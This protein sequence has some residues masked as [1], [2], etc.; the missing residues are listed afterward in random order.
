MGQSGEKS[1]KAWT[2]AMAENLKRIA[3][4]AGYLPRGIG[5]LALD[6]G[7][8]EKT[9]RKALDGGSQS[10]NPRT[11]S[12]LAKALKVREEELVLDEEPCLA[13]GV[14]ELERLRGTLKCFV[15]CPGFEA[16]KAAL[17][18]GKSVVIV[19]PP[20]SGKTF[21]AVALAAEMDLR[22]VLL[23]EAVLAERFEEVRRLLARA[24]PSVV[25]LD[26]AF[27]VF[28]AIPLAPEVTRL[29][30][31]R[32]HL[33][34]VTSRPVPYSQVAVRATFDAA[35][36]HTLTLGPCADPEELISLAIDSC[37]DADKPRL[38]SRVQEALRERLARGEGGLAGEI[39]FTVQL[40]R[41]TSASAERVPPMSEHPLADFARALLA[42]V[43][44]TR[45]L[46]LIAVA[47]GDGLARARFI[48]YFKSLLHAWQGT[49]HPF[50]MM[51]PEDRFGDFHSVVISGTSIGFEHP[52]VAEAFR[53]AIDQDF[54]SELFAAQAVLAEIIGAD[55]EYYTN[56]RYFH[57]SVWGLSA[58]LALGNSGQTKEILRL[59][60][61]P[62]ESIVVPHSRRTG[63]IRPMENFF[64]GT[65]V[66]TGD[67]VIVAAALLSRAAVSREI[68]SQIL[69]GIAE[70]WESGVLELG[71][72][73]AVWDGIGWDQC[74]Q[75]VPHSLRALHLVGAYDRLVAS[76]HLSHLR[77]GEGEMFVPRLVHGEGEG[78]RL[79]VGQDDF[80]P[81]AATISHRAR[82]GER[83][84]VVEVGEHEE[85]RFPFWPVLTDSGI[86]SLAFWID[87]VMRLGFDE[88]F[89]AS[90]ESSIAITGRWAVENGAAPAFIRHLL[91]GPR[92]AEQRRRIFPQEARW[93]HKGAT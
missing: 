36:T 32:R 70:L 10:F 44:L 27:G 9:L 16:A 88:G 29:F 28:T 66:I 20:L 40:L 39:W 18:L 79:L 22:T 37:L 57:A 69:S 51:L 46:F 85:R 56:G 83:E 63:R 76:V 33:W 12:G 21:T 60:L 19:G 4:E 87:G 86:P 54:L 68:A 13:L 78:V 41:E 25:I 2:P 80:F 7:I 75:F 53:H 55:E 5:A 11:L 65:H 49:I 62:A 67:W 58:G 71:A 48:R 26:D 17:H 81:S 42:S 45:R 77:R 84:V 6:A 59:L 91:T 93:K 23:P 30:L 14:P 89:F 3:A 35:A 47:L 74:P 82:R 50:C 24:E 15:R 61:Y 73:M 43:D 92:N 72:T 1:R 8:D 90:L 34:I 52:I 64:C 38:R 31:N